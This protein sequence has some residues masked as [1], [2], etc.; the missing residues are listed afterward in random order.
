MALGPCDRH[1]GTRR[2]FIDCVHLLAKNRNVP[3]VPQ[4]P[5][6]GQGP[7]PLLTANLITEGF[8]F[9]F[10]RYCTLR[11]KLLVHGRFLAIGMPVSLGSRRH[12]DRALCPP[13]LPVRLTWH[14]YGQLGDLDL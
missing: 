13:I 14:D 2:C 8:R 5:L 4:S 12:E 7:A 9:N 6:C 10:N 11:C 1:N 3:N